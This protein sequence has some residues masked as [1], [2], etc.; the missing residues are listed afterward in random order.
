MPKEDGN[1]P[2]SISTSAGGG[3]INKGW[4]WTA[5]SNN[6]GQSDDVYSP[7]G[8]SSGDNQGR[9]WTVEHG[10]RGGDELNRP[11]PGL[12]YGWPVVTYGIEYSGEKIGDGQ[13]QAGGTV[14]PVYYW[15]P[16]IGPSGMALYDKDLFPAWKNQFL[17]GGLVSTG[18]V[19]L[20]LDGDKVVTEAY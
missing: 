3:W 6:E 10:P 4:S 16:V 20:K 1:K 8:R 12:N 13:T 7:R 14:Q 18:L 17:I 5:T 11:R 9:L 15:D 2:G 19:V